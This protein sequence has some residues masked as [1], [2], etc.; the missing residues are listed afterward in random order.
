MGGKDKTGSWICGRVCVDAGDRGWMV[1]SEVI[2]W[3]VI[4][5]MLSGVGTDY[6]PVGMFR[7]MIMQTWHNLL[8]EV[9]CEA[10][11]RDIEYMR[12]CGFTLDGKK[13]DSSTLCRFR[14]RLNKGGLFEKLLEKVNESLETKGLKVA[15]GKY[16][17]TDATLIQS[18]RRPRKR[19]ERR[20]IRI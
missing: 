2:D 5:E 18:A 4:K 3:E 17:S 12:F 9:I 6:E 13:A 7:M 10:M 14:G 1:L 20:Y 8:D 19:M 15:Q 11:K 16:V